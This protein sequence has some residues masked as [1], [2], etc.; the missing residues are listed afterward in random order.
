M[1]VSERTY[2]VSNNLANHIGFKTNKNEQYYIMLQRY[3]FY[4]DLIALNRQK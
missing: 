2:K 4:L 3:Y 1:I